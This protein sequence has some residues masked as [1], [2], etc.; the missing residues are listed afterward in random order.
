MLS[1]K[2]KYGLHAILYLGAHYGRGPVLTSE[3]A[4]QERI[5]KK[6]LE[7]ILLDLKHRGI[8]QSK[9]GKNGGYLLSK[10]PAHITA[11]AVIRALD[12]PITPVPCLGAHSYERC[13][14]CADEVSCGIRM[15]MQEVR[16][17]MSAV[18]E[19]TTIADMMER[20]ELAKQDAGAATY[21]I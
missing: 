20:S 16:D 12:G 5:P 19:K 15:C 8:V 6:F 10:S 17:A 18:L 7:Q 4:E 21:Q 3:L 9:M 13:S 11:G 1:M 14:D 2:A